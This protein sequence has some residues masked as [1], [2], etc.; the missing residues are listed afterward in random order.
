MARDRPRAP[1]LN[2]VA[3]SSGL[4]D[5]WSLA[6]LRAACPTELVEVSASTDGYLKGTVDEHETLT[7]SFADDFLGR[8]Q[9]DDSTTWRARPSRLHLH[10][11]QC[12][13]VM[14]PALQADAPPPR[15]RFPRLRRPVLP[16]CS[17][18]IAAAEDAA[19]APWSAV[20]GVRGD[21]RCP[22]CRSRS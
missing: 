11:A 7:M 17:P 4:R 13:L 2:W 12:P 10:L 5:R 16:D 9:A 3:S 18:S 8:V 1:T 19:P 14:L 22:A 15:L 6:Y 21:G 20:G